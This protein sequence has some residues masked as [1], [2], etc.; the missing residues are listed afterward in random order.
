MPANSLLAQ[1]ELLA[2]DIGRIGFQGDF[3]RP[4]A[5]GHASPVVL[6]LPEFAPLPSLRVF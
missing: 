4:S 6:D 1:R 2:Q 5:F 3:T